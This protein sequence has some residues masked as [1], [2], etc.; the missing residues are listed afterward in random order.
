MK[1]LLKKKGVDRAPKVVTS[2]FKANLVPAHK[3][4]LV[5]SASKKTHISAGAATIIADLQAKRHICG[6]AV[7]IILRKIEVYHA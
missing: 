1:N 4:L 5:A 7:Q 6:I 2:K 3:T